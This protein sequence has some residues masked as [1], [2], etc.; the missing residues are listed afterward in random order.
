MYKETRIQNREVLVGPD[1]ILKEEP[2]KAVIYRLSPAEA[3]LLRETGLDKWLNPV[4][5]P[6]KAFGKPSLAEHFDI[7]SSSSNLKLERM[8]PGFTTSTVHVELI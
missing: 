5:Y 4:A 8:F 7:F 6:A 2:Y 3:E 1:R